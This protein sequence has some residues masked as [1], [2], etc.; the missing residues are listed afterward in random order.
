MHAEALLCCQHCPHR[1]PDTDT[2]AATQKE[3][4]ME[5][6]EREGQ[7]TRTEEIQYEQE[8]YKNKKVKKKQ[9]YKNITL[10]SKNKTFLK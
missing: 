3:R 9:P 1:R 10:K 6:N 2:A 7:E 8:K 4:R 5:L